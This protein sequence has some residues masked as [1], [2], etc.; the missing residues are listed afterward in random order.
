VRNDPPSQ[1]EIAAIRVAVV[2]ALSGAPD[3]SPAEIMAVGGT[4][5][6]LVKMLPEAIAD[7]LLTRERI[8]RIQEILATEDAATISAAY[9]VNPVRARLLPAGGAILDAILERYGAESIRVSEAGLREGVIL[10]VDHAGPCWRDRL[11]DL[12]HGW[13]T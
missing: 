5:S 7:R 4:A 3:V 12:A 6:N 10:A 1:T 11:S 8:A 9:G 13:R 2:D